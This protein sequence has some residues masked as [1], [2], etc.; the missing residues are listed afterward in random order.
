MVINLISN[1]L[2]F[3]HANEI[4]HVRLKLLELDHSNEVELQIEVVDSGVGISET[5][6]PY[7]FL[8]YFKSTDPASLS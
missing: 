3:S 4:I 5:E 1:A 2:K 6:L 8:P 7:I